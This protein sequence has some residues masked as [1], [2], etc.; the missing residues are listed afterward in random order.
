MDFTTWESLSCSLGSMAENYDVLGLCGT[1]LKSTFVIERA[2]ARGGF[3]I[4]YRGRHLSLHKEIAIKVYCPI[5]IPD[6]SL[7]Q[8]AIAHFL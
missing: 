6:A 3:G 2:V 5:A 1:T 7:E 4:V 8:E